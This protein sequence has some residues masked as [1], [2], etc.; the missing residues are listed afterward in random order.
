M[1]KRSNPDFDVEGDFEEEDREDE[2]DPSDDDVYVVEAPRGQSPFD[3]LELLTLLITP[4]GG[5]FG[6]LPRKRETLALVSAALLNEGFI[7]TFHPP[8]AFL[9]KVRAIA[10]NSTGDRN[11]PAVSRNLAELAIVVR[12]M[13]EHPANQKLSDNFTK[14]RNKDL[15]LVQFIEAS[16]TAFAQLQSD[17]AVSKLKPSMRDFSRKYTLGLERST[18]VNKFKVP[19][20]PFCHHPYVVQVE[21]PASLA[22]TNAA[23]RADNERRRTQF[24]VSKTGKNGQLIKK[25]P[26][27]RP[28]KE[29]TLQCDCFVRNCFGNAILNKQCLECS[30]RASKG[31]PY[32]MVRSPSGVGSICPCPICVC[33]CQAAFSVRALPP[34]A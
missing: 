18:P 3:E 21:T 8:E 15:N 7:N 14:A 12:D 24:L 1:A 26:Q 11:A 6:Q 30:Q 22:A 31:S 33:V 23:I 4:A 34:P 19:D 32:A 28:E 17:H 2:G 29:A 5:S 10:A 20:C 9:A 27:G 16:N 13:L 25:E